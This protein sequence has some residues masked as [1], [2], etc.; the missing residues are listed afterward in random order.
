MTV[1]TLA[2]QLTLLR[3]LLVPVFAL[4][5]FYGLPGW[6][7][8]TFVVAG[9]TDAF[10]GLI[11]RRTG[12][13]STLG[14]WL[15]RWRT[16]SAAHDGTRHLRPQCFAGRPFGHARDTWHDVPVRRRARTPEEQYGVVSLGGRARAVETD[17]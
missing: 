11:A 17:R 7:L 2:N 4:C 9:A 3:L 13:L 12:H 14:A 6:A 10:D 8:A 5:M 15:D 16:S 1:L